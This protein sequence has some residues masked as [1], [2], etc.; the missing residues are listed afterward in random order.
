M[1][2]FGVMLDMS[3]NAVMKPSEVKNFAKVIK[4]FGYNMIQLYM[5]D[6]YE[7]ENEP[8]FGYFRGRYTVEELK[9]MVTHCDEI[10]VELI[11]CIQTL[12]HLNQIFRWG[13]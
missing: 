1:K 4:S 3:R 6:T 12:A 9:D 11:P 13:D 8:Y 5:E 7:V 10:G 2:K